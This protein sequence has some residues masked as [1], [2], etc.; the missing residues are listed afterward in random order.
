MRELGIA[1]FATGVVGVASLARPDF[2]LPVAIAAAVFYGIAGVHHLSE[3]GRNANPTIAMTSDLL[4]ALI[5]AAYVG[6][7]ALG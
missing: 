6:Y 7:V 2:V 1:N 5:F 3:H 4:A